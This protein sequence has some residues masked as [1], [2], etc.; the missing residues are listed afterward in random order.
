MIFIIFL[1]AH[2]IGDFICQTD[3]MAI[4]KSSKFDELLNHIIVYTI[5]LS[6]IISILSIIFNYNINNIF[7]FIGINFIFH[8]I[9]DFFTS[10]LN[11]YLWK[12]DNRHWFFVSIGFDQFLHIAILY[13]TYLLCF[14]K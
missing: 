11:S 12:N 2:F 10:K 1:F 14:I 13:I 4:N 5:S 7:I 6:I 8:L 9:I 3:K